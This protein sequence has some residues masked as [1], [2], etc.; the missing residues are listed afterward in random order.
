MVILDHVGHTVTHSM[1]T[2]RPDQFKIVGLGGCLKLVQVGLDYATG[3]IMVD[4]A[5]G[6][7]NRRREKFR[8]IKHDVP[9]GNDWTPL[10]E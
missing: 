2:N 6:D 8:R 9:A 3:R 4:E 5:L 10:V 7:I 1:I